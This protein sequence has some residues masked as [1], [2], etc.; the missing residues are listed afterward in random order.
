M[1]KHLSLFLAASVAILCQLVACD[2]SFKDTLVAEYNQE[3][4]HL[5]TGIGLGPKKL[6]KDVFIMFYASWCPHC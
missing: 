2:H 3:N 5:K 4:L 1:R 6:E